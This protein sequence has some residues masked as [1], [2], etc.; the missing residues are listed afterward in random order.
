MAD[1]TLDMMLV[2]LFEGFPSSASQ[3]TDHTVDAYKLALHGV[4]FDA[5][6]TA[7]GRFLRGE[8]ERNST[9]I[10]SAAELT[11]EA[12]RIDAEIEAK[13]RWAD[14][15]FVEQGS[16]LWHAIVEQRGGRQMPSVDRGGV[17]GWYVQSAVLEAAKP[18]LAKYEKV[19]RVLDA[20]PTPQLKRIEAA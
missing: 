19:M 1:L 13:R 8:V 2:M 12:K 10:P 16:P 7:C 4:S 20:I 9:F 3:I 15:T 6:R 11:A 5:I 18:L 14:T 17:E